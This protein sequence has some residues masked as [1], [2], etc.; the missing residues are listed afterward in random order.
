M[1]RFKLGATIPTVQYGNI[2]PEFEV[3]A[4]TYE[5]AMAIAEAQLIPFWNKHVEVGKELK[6]SEGKLIKGFVGGEIYYDDATHTYTNENG[7]IYLSSTKYAAKFAAPFDKQMIATATAK[8]FKVSA[9]DVATMWELK[10]KISRDLG[11]AL[12]EAIE[13]RRRFQTLSETM[14]KETHIHLSPMVKKPVDELMELLPLGK[15]AIEAVVIDHANKQVG[16]IDLLK[17]TGNQKCEV[18][19]FKT[20]ELEKNVNMYWKQLEFTANILERNDW[21]VPKLKIYHWNEK[22]ELHEKEFNYDP[23]IIVR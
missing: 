17:I 1:I 14:A 3:E 21:R 6:T 19:D 23:T 12:H 2:M 18:I 13:L 5:E 20:G 7:D 8:K 15:E 22:W 16:R 10:A 11:T 9:D 4:D